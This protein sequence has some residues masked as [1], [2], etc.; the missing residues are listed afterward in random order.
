MNDIYEVMDRWG[1]GQHQITVVL[2]GS[3]L[4]LASRACYHME[5]NHVL[6][7]MMTKAL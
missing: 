7:A 6:S 1:H 4:Q 5:R 2:T 3:L